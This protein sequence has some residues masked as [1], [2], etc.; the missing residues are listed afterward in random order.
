[1]KFYNK[2]FKSVVLI[3]I[4][5]IGCLSDITNER[6]VKNNRSNKIILNHN[7]KRKPEIT[8]ANTFWKF[9]G[10]TK[11]ELS[12]DK[13][14]VTE[15]TESENTS[16]QN[17]YD[18]VNYHKLKQHDQQQQH[19]DGYIQPSQPDDSAVDDVYDDMQLDIAVKAKIIKA[20]KK[21]QTEKYSNPSQEILTKYLHT[22]EIGTGMKVYDYITGEMRAIINPEELDELSVLTSLYKFENCDKS[23][24]QWYD[25]CYEGDNCHDEALASYLQYCSD[26]ISNNLYN[27]KL[28]LESYKN[29]EHQIEE[30]CR[31]AYGK[32][33]PPNLC[34]KKPSQNCNLDHMTRCGP[35]AC[36]LNN[37]TC[38]WEVGSLVLSVAVM[39]G[40]VL[41]LVLTPGGAAASI[42]TKSLTF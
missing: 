1:M 34:W 12:L 39:I 5:I 7:D 29:R 24:Q 36:A 6:K 25:W 2:Q 33:V 10:Y 18:M 38:A 3:F 9:F 17:I 20:M 37:K 27:I 15:P 31:K 23:F 13:A 16:N 21:I 40:K 35:L 11:V 30:I 22:G 42:I 32:I 4:I 41:L 19:H 8:F 26:N 28:M 14:Q